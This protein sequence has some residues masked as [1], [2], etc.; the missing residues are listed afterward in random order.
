MKKFTNSGQFKYGQNVK[1]L[2]GNKYGKLTVLR[3]ATEDEISARG[4][5]NT[6]QNVYWLVRCACGIEPFLV[7]GFALTGKD[8]RRKTQS[9]LACKKCSRR[10]AAIREKKEFIDSI[11]GQQSGRLTI[12]RYWGTKKDRRT[13][14]LCSCSCDD[15]KTPIYLYSSFK[16]L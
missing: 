15:I 10:D 2:T 8:K 14:I 3:R 9:A 6:R 4:V 11:I 16:A 7:L 5:K 12:L 13:K 1:D